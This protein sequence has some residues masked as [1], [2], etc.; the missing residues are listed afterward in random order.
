[1]TEIQQNRYDQLIRRVNNIVSGGSMVGD[2]LS[3]LFPTIDVERVPGELLILMGTRI[4]AGRGNVNAGAGVRPQI[5]LFNPGGSGTIITVTTLIV[6]TVEAQ[7]L[8]WAI[9]D[10]ALTTL[11]ARGSL[12]DS[13]VRATASN[14]AVGE[15]RFQSTA[16]PIGGETELISLGSTSHK[17]SDENGVAV[18][19][20]GFGLG[21]EGTT[22]ATQII[23]AFYWRERTMEASEETPVG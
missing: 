19:S 16:V 21:V 14:T 3:E 4:G 15:I 13:R 8:S 18:L 6:S 7:T 22:L 2:A 12:R 10:A 20:P 11:S 23:A 17:I 1:M 5:Q 9:G